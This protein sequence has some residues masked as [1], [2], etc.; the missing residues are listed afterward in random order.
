[1]VKNDLWRAF[2]RGCQWG[3]GDQATY[4]AILCVSGVKDT[5]KTNKD[6]GMLCHIQVE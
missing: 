1:M 3:G 5:A 2:M 4:T 6:L